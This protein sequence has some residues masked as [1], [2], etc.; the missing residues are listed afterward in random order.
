MIAS[1]RIKTVTELAKSWKKV[2]RE[3][4]NLFISSSGHR[5]SKSSHR[6]FEGQE[7]VEIVSNNGIT[8]NYSKLNGK[9]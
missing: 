1:F 9:A 4:Q 7:W 6:N 3:F 5:K 2:N 8:A